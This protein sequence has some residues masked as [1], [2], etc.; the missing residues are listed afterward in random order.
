MGRIDPDPSADDDQ[1]VTDTK[2]DLVHGLLKAHST[3]VSWIYRFQSVPGSTPAR[4][5][6]VLLA[7]REV[8]ELR[9]DALPRATGRAI[10]I[11]ECPV[12]VTLAALVSFTS[13]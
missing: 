13:S 4:F 9:H 10:R 12:G 1:A 5:T 7:R 6:T 11:D 8:T 3:S 2:N